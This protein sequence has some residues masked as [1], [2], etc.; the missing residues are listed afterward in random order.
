MLTET[1]SPAAMLIAPAD[2]PGDAGDQDGA[3]GR[4]WRPATPTTRP[5]VDTMPSLAPS[6]A[7]PQPVEAGGEALVVGLVVVGADL[8]VGRVGAH[9]PI[10]RRA[11]TLRNEGEPGLR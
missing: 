2:Q 8:E 10:V 11:G 3:G 1:Y 9:G 5:A 7:G 6:T 4:W